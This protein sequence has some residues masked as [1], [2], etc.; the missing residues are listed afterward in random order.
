MFFPKCVYITKNT[1]F[2]PILH[3]FAPLNDVCA[4]SDWSWKTTLI[5]WIDIRVPP[6]PRIFN[7]FGL[8]LLPEPLVHLKCFFFCLFCFLFF[9]VLKCPWMIPWYK[10]CSSSLEVLCTESEHRIPSSSRPSTC[11]R[12]PL[13]SRGLAF[14]EGCKGEA[15][16]YLRKFLMS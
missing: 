15:P 7:K 13:G 14:V 9:F 3:V 12:C 4:Y 8:E 10:K 2:F 16:S 11:A 6:P 5:T 1:P